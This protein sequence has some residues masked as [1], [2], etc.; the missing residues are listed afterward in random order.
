MTDAT[1]HATRNRRLLL[2]KQLYAHALDHSG[3]GSVLDKMIAVHNFH[4]AV[5]ITLRAIAL[6]HEVRVERELNIDFESLLNEID[7]FEPFRSKGE[8]L[9]YRQELR[10]LNSV[11][12]LVQHHAHEPE[13]ST[14]DEWRVFS[15]R[16][17]SKAFKQYF[18]VDFEALSPVD[19]IGDPRLR[20]IL[21]LSER[22]NGRS[23]WDDATC[24]DKLAFQFAMMSLRADL[25]AGQSSW[26]FFAGG[27]SVRGLGLDDLLKKVDKRF[28]ELEQYT[29]VLASGVTPGAYARFTRAK[30]FVHIMESG[31]PIF[32]R[33]MGFA[34]MT[35]EESEWIHEFVVQTIVRWQNAG[36]RPTVPSW[37]EEGCDAFLAGEGTQ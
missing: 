8:R 1:D 9:P 5:E 18:G 16:F 22:L 33:A 15:K 30:I 35:R 4:N 17:L 23:A 28:E 10:K 21:Q 6:E 32:D 29:V 26:A 7:R 25:P 3:Y 36:L 20:R 12:N 24:A 19:L 2:A 14:M 31:A 11:R 13:G 37:Q 27:R 34:S